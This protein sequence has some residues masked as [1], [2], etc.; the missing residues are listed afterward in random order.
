MEELHRAELNSETQKKI[1]GIL[2]NSKRNGCFVISG[3]GAPLGPLP[4]GP[5]LNVLVDL[6]HSESLSEIIRLVVSISPT[7]VMQADARG[8]TI[9]HRKLRKKVGRIRIYEHTC[10]ILFS[11]YFFVIKIVGDFLV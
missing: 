1:L 3:L 8:R 10:N 11:F 4:S 2:Q 6:D 5:L 9:L 7:V